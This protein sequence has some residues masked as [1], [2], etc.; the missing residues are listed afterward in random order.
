MSG[1]VHMLLNPGVPVYVAPDRRDGMLVAKTKGADCAVLDDAFQHR[2]AARVADLV[3]LSADSWR[4]TVHLL[5]VGPFREP[6]SSLA[7]ASLAIVTVKA[8]DETRVDDV[9]DTIKRA[10]PSV[11]TAVVRLVLG[12]LRRRPPCRRST[13]KVARTER[14]RTGPDS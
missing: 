8:A 13:E 1:D 5:P 3:L 2:M 14:H 4:G 7:R 12:E 6:L 9:L 10:V 11:P